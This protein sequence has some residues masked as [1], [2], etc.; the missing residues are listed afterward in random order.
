MTQGDLFRDEG[1]KQVEENANLV[2]LKCAANHV[3]R[4]AK[5]YPEFTTDLIWSWMDLAGLTTHDNRA[6]GAVMKKAQAEGW[7]E[8]TDRVVKSTRPVCHS[9]PIRVWR[10]KLI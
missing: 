4:T 9:R 8:P 2:W 10:S 3:H 5:N 1:I 6:M 7:I